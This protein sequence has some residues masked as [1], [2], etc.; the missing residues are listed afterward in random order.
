[1][2]PSSLDSE[3]LAIDLEVSTA[4]SPVASILN[5][6]LGEHG[7]G[8]LKIS[9]MLIEQFDN[10]LHQLLP[11]ILN[12]LGAPIDKPNSIAIEE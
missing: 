9:P 2:A 3:K 7:F 10:R 5:E 8:I 11:W 12:E 4:R 1:M 6:R